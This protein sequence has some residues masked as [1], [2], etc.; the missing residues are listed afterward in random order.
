MIWAGGCQGS[1]TSTSH[2]RRAN[3]TPVSSAQLRTR[4]GRGHLEGAPD[5]PNKDLCALVQPHRPSPAFARPMT[6]QGGT[7]IPHSYSA[8]LEESDKAAGGRE[9]LHAKLGRA[10]LVHHTLARL[11]GACTHCCTCSMGGMH[12]AATGWAHR[13]CV[14]SLKPGKLLVTSSTSRSAEPSAAR[15]R[16]SALPWKLRCSTS[17]TCTHPIL[18][19]LNQLKAWTLPGTWGLASL[20]LP[21]RVCSWRCQA[22]RAA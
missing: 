13:Y 19:V 15:M 16:R 7:G 2:L 18:R 20:A 6:G 5:V 9:L 12:T 11:Q 22:P 8:K 3:M 21:C 14:S 4:W 10:K 17:P 1:Q